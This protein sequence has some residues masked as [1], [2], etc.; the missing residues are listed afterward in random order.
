MK[1]RTKKLL[2]ALAFLLLVAAV[3]GWTAAE[4]RWPAVNRWAEA[5]LLAAL[6]AN[7]LRTAAVPLREISWRRAVAG[8]AEFEFHALRVRVEDASA[9]LG[10]AVWRERAALDVAVRGAR[11]TLDLAK[12]AELHARPAA[13]DA[14]ADSRDLAFEV[15][16]GVLEVRQ[17]DWRREVPFAGRIRWTGGR[18][19]FDAKLSSPELRAGLSLASDGKLTVQDAVV[20][21]AAW[22]ELAET[23][24][25]EALARVRPGSVERAEVSGT[26]QLTDGRLAETSLDVLLRGVRWSEPGRELSVAELRT[27]A[28]L[29]DGRWKFAPFAAPAA[30]GAVGEFR[31]RSGAVEVARS[32]EGTWKFSVRDAV[33]T[34]PG[35]AAEGSV[36][37]QA[38]W[39]DAA[40]P[41]QAELRFDFRRIEHGPVRVGEG[42]LNA[43]WDGAVLKLRSERVGLVAP[44]PASATTLDVSVSDLFAGQPI[45]AGSVQLAGAWTDWLAGA[46][47][48]ISPGELALPVS[49]T[50]LL[51]SGQESVRLETKLPP[52]ARRVRWRDATLEFE[53]G[54]KLAVTA[55]REF[56][57]GRLSLEGTEVRANRGDL[58]LTAGSFEATIRWPRVWWSAVRGWRQA[59]AERAWRELLWVGDYDFSLA[60]AA[61]RDGAR[62]ELRDASLRA[63]SRGAELSAE[64]GADFGVAAGELRWGDARVEGF[65]LQGVAGFDR[66]RCELAGALVGTPL[67]ATS[68]QQ[69]TWQDGLAVA[70]TFAVPELALTGDES[71]TTWAPWTRGVRFSGRISASGTTTWR[72]GNA[73]SDATV[74]VRDGAV[75]ETRTGAS[76]EG[77]AADLKLTTLAPVVSAPAQKL[78][79][80]GA[81]L[82]GVAFSDG[83]LDF[84]LL[85]GG[86]IKVDDLGVT[87]FGGRLQS[88]AFTTAFENPELNALV[89]ATKLQLGDVLRL[90]PRLPV[91]ASGAVSGAVP[92]AWRGGRLTI[93]S[94]VL[95]LVAGE[96]GVLHLP[97]D[98]QP[99]TTGRAANTIGYRTLRRVENAILELHFNR[100]HVETYPSD[101]PGQSVRV[102]FVG[103]PAGREITAPV[104]F[105]FNVNAPLEDFL[106]WSMKGDISLGGVR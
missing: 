73:A 35:E 106:D 61:L 29:A 25:P 60:N 67:R 49:F 65:Q 13:K 44:V 53:G 96:L 91:S 102:R 20:R 55:D 54:A 68:V 41:T 7:G 4:G 36:E 23:H 40:I 51:T 69:I 84:A 28:A 31:F 46:G 88:G 32:D 42:T 19:S 18:L 103:A 15:A 59:P 16:D 52:A 99:L 26:L 83:V 37:A 3:L 79:F 58:A 38:R 56:V 24:W 62:V 98:F 97:E 14:A 57:S 75:R 95:D 76:C 70:G 9:S 43:V 22:R 45:A 71:W 64:G 33:V 17:G 66:A 30:E 93:G 39:A 104:S 11:V 81:K 48:E 5:R 47:L 74:T 101:A 72:A 21:P 1:R 86:R 85:A 87:A 90:F 92:L 8:P 82:A 89:I 12:L 6:Q 94:G 63:R 34:G 100:L 2:L 10:W 77:I 80:T 105:D 27:H 50:A 78:T